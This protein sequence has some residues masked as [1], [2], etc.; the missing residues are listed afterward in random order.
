MLHYSK[1]NFISL[2]LICNVFIVLTSVLNFLFT[3]KL[4]VHNIDNKI[5]SIKNKDNYTVG[6]ETI[7]FN[8]VTVQKQNLNLSDD[9]SS[10]KYT[11][12]LIN[13]S[14]Y[15]IRSIHLMNVPKLD[16]L[17]GLKNPCFFVKNPP[18]NDG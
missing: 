9:I 15:K 17:K 7:N 18:D 3:Y 5:I 6:L 13:A 4:L 16:F 14:I 1:N 11:N 8:N 10:K 12:I 2:I